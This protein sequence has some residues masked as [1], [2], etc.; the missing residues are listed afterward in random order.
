MGIVRLSLSK[1]Y[2][3]NEYNFSLNLNL[4]L[5]HLTLVQNLSQL[6]CKI[7]SGKLLDIFCI[8]F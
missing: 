5:K 4:S 7:P 6:P 8:F 2:Y 1:P 3:L